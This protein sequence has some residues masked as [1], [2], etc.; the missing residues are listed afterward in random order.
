M[1]AGAQRVLATLWRVDDAAT[2]EL[3]QLFYRGLLQQKRRPAEA[4]QEAQ[5]A[6]AR[7]ARWKSP[8]YWSGFVLQGEPR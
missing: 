5:R 2:A 8:Y 4:L 3:M 6:L 1:H 7:Q